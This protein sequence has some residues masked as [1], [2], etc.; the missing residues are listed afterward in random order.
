MIAGEQTCTPETTARIADIQTSPIRDNTDGSLAPATGPPPQHAARRLTPG[1]PLA[2][3][4]ADT[5]VPARR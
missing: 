1:Y 3:R 4:R 2:Q 5:R